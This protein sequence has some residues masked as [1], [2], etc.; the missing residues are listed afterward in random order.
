VQKRLYELPLILLFV[1]AL[2][3]QGRKSAPKKCPGVI[4]HI[5]MDCWE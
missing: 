5:R 1:E 3:G 2:A 4:V